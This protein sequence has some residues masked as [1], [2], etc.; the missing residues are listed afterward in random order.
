MTEPTAHTTLLDGIYALGEQVRAA[1]EADDVD[2]FVDLVEQRGRLIEQLG[3]LDPPAP[4]AEDLT[5]QAAR[6]K[7]QHAHIG[8]ATAARE[9]RLVVD[10]GTLKQVQ[11]A[12]VQYGG[13]R[14]R[15]RF[16][17]KNLHG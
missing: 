16:L 8:A 9:K 13:H 11:Q 10:Q 15:P 4:G 2:A 3:A 1:L 17:N 5:E 7:R 6:L 14:E 12:R